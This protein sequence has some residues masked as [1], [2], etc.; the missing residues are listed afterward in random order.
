[1]VR[2]IGEKR[3]DPYSMRTQTRLTATA[4][5]VILS[6]SLA[7]H[8]RADTSVTTATT[9]PL[10]TSTAGDTTVSSAGTITLTSG[11]AITVDS[12]NV[13]DFAGTAAM[14]ASDSNSTGILITDVPNRTKALTLGG[15]ITVTDDY[16]ASDTTDDAIVD[17]PWAEGTGRYGIHSVGAS[18]FTG[19]VDITSALDVEG[20]Q[21]Y[22]VRFE[23]QVHGAFTYDGSATIIGDNSTAIALDKDVTG[24]VYL[25][26]SASVLGAN[27]SAITLKGDIGGSLIIDGTYY[28][29]GYSSTSSLTT[30]EL[31]L[32]DPSLNLLQSGPLVSI[33]SNVANGVLLGAAVTS[34]VD[35]NTDEDG[36][37][38]TDTVQ[39]TATLTQYGGSPALQVGSSSND[40]TLG[41]LTYASTA[42]DPPT[43]NYGLLIR[44]AVSS[45]GVYSSV[46]T[47]ALSIGGTGYATTITNGIG[48]A[49]TVYTSAYGANSTAIAL[50][51]GATTPQLDITGTVT[52]STTTATTATTTNDVTTYATVGGGTTAR[53]IDIAD[54]ATLGAVNVAESASLTATAI[55]STANATAI[56][57]QSNTLTSITNS[58]TISATI[59]ASDDNGDS[60]ADAITGTATA[61]DASTNSV[62]LNLVQT[63]SAPDD[64][65][66]AAPYIYGK[67]LL[68]S[69]NDSIRS[70]GGFIYGAIDYGAG[71]GNFILSNAATYLGT[72][73]S[74][75]DIAMD[76]D[77]DSQAGLLS[78]SSVKLSSLHVGDGSTLGLGLDADNPTAAILTN[79]GAAVFDD[80]ATLSLSVNRI[81]TTPVTFTVMTGASIDLGTMT[82]STLDGYIPYLYHADLTTN[83]SDTALYAN[84]RLKTQAEGNFS[85][86][87][88]N[89]LTPILTAVAQDSGAQTSLLSAVTRSDFAKVYNQYFPDYSGENLLTLSQGAASLTRSLGSLTAIPDN[90]GGQY[91][92]QEYG[93]HTQRGVGDTAGFNA[94]GFS[95]S[96]GRERAVYGNQMVGAYMSLTTASPRDTYATAQETSATSDTTFGAYWRLNSKALKAWAHAGAGYDQFKTVRE[97]VTSNVTH[98]ANARWNGY[99][100]SAGAGASYAMTVG[101]IGITPQWQVDYYRLSET[102]HSEK[103]GGD[104]F[105]LAVAARQGQLLSSSARMAVSYNRAFIRPELWLGYKDNLSATIA[106]TVANFAN[107]DPFTLTGGAIKGGGPL[108]G[109]RVSADNAYS[110]F[111]LEGEYEKVGGVANTS[112]SL[113][114]RFQF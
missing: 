59:T 85:S 32:L 58:G 73:T 82:T 100:L 72:M 75:G 46:D 84:F 27:S 37:G 114:T 103:G 4:L 101:L 49:G 106:D 23:N 71:T 68:G 22:G 99:S 14:S 89:A 42:I 60:V 28:G 9:T 57:D 63:D 80:G 96:G 94:T 26:G 107:Q 5:G 8:A 16:T 91:W 113:R 10:S 66:I 112:L 47:H 1:M 35:S 51:S 54:G 17:A 50:L 104:Y 64:D 109:F 61:I 20:N 48:I 25:S 88:Y 13:V 15:A 93:F 67:I 38:L 2:A 81:V 62:G 87:A 12:D 44:G 21:S 19:D 95:F 34:T 83:D 102:A 31:A 36:D 108:A 92:L 52:A 97:L 56:R 70:S 105:D 55:G 43:V 39:S 65:D 86:N 18:P 78:G 90:D 53:A 6:G 11:T 110:Y 69:G 45:Y 30:A 79:S 98:I 76:I 74:A 29:T 41:A 111:A 77:G 7:M 3:L 40:M 24:N 33:G